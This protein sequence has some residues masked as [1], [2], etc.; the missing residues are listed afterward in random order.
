[1]KG[2]NEIEE[3]NSALLHERMSTKRKNEWQ[4]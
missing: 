2:E 1:M 3:T 4:N